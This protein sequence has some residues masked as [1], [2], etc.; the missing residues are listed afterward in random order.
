MGLRHYGRE[1]ALQALYQI[2]ILGS[3]TR[4]DLVLFFESFPADDRARK[5]AVQ[6]V[7]GVRGEQTALDT[8]LAATLEHWSVKRLSRVDHNILRLAL[9]ELLRLDDVP[10]RVTI[11]EAIELAKRYGDKES[12]RFVNGV[13]DQLAERLQLKHKGEGSSADKIE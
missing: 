8:E 1:L 9:Y 4:D 13:L 6:L 3:G 10:A 7:E 2:D 12:G 5:F 11:D